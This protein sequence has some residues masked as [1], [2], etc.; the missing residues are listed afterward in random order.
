MRSGELSFPFLLKRYSGCAY[1]SSVAQLI[2]TRL[3]DLLSFAFIMAFSLVNL[4]DRGIIKSSWI[5]GSVLCLLLAFPVVIFSLQLIYRRGNQPNSD[6]LVRF[7][8]LSFLKPIFFRVKTF[9]KRIFQELLRYGDIIL[10][11]KLLGY[12]LLIW[13]VL[14]LIFWKVLLL[15]G[16]Q[17]SFSEVVVG[18]SLANLT[19]LLPLNTVGNIGTLEAGW[20]LGFTMLGFDSRQVFAVGLLMHTVVIVAAGLYA[21][22]SWVFL[23]PRT[24]RS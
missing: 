10:H 22:I 24:R 18:S 7:K 2:L 19:Q 13:L 21:F 16:I 3:Y 5:L 20:V 17:M 14:F 1:S 9:L 11:L 23:L 8:K 15:A 6:N 4:M 12:S